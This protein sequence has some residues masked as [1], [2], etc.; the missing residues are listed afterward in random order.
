MVARRRRLSSPS[1]DNPKGRNE[2]PEGFNT[3]ALIYSAMRQTRITQTEIA[4]R[5]GRNPSTVREV[6]RRR[7]TQASILHEFSIA[8]GVDLF[9]PLSDNL[10]E[11]IRSNPDKATIDTLHAEKE[12]LKLQVAE[13]KTQLA[14]LRE[15][16]GYLKKMID[17]LATK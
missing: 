17:I 2:I 11:H 7:S 4:R 14:Q 8:L 5:T 10:P 12:A 9:R 6:R 1:D 16:N 3:G 13:L 15:D